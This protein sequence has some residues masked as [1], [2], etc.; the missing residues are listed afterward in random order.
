MYAHVHKF[1]KFYQK[2]EM[3]SLLPSLITYK[4]EHLFIYLFHE[5]PLLRIAQSYT[6]PVFDWVLSLT[7]VYRKNQ[8]A[9]YIFRLLRLRKLC[10]LNVAFPS[11]KLISCLLCTVSF[12]SKGVLLNFMQLCLSIF[13]FIIFPYIVLFKKS[14]PFLSQRYSLT[15]SLAIKVLLITLTTVI[16]LELITRCE[17]K[18]YVYFISSCE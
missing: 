17:V 8:E 15:Y 3:L 4:F 7:S 2:S 11:L 10:E 18:I 16:Y 5:S 1:L 9:L 6:L 12:V 14:F 13:P